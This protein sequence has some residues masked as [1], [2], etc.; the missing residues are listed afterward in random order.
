M[1]LPDKIRAMPVAKCLDLPILLKHAFM[2]GWVSA[3]GTVDKAAQ[4]A[5]FNYKP[6]E[7]ECTR[8]IA[9]TNDL[10]RGREAM[11]AS[12][13]IC[14]GAGRTRDPQDSVDDVMPLPEFEAFQD[15]AEA[16]VGKKVRAA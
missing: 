1:T 15:D 14:H 16:L 10:R 11:T 2:S 9:A 4:V 5:W 8:L 3:D 6:S 12:C 13:P 7:P